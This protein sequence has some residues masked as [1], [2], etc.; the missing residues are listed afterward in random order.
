V[1]ILGILIIAGCATRRKK[2]ETSKLGKFY[3][4]TT[5]EFNGYFNANEIMKESYAILEDN[6]QDNYSKI[7]EPYNFTAATDPKIV[8]PQLDKAIEKVARVAA[9][10][11]PGDWVDD[12]YVLMGQAQFLKKDFETSLETLTFFENEFNPA[13]P[14]GKN[15]KKK[16]ASTKA[17]KEEQENRKKELAND[18]KAKEKEREETKKIADKQREEDKKAREQAAK[19]RKS[20]SR[21][22]SR[23]STRTSSRTRSTTPAKEEPQII[24]VIPPTSVDSSKQ[25]TAVVATKKP[26]PIPEK[27]KKEK[28]DKSAY[29][30]GILWLAMG[31]TKTQQYSSSEYIL[32]RLS[33]MEGLDKKVQRGI[34]PAMADA[35]IQQKAYDEALEYLEQA[36]DN[37]ASKELKGRYAFI[38]GQL[39]QERKD[40]RNAVNYFELARKN[41]GK[42]FKMK[43]MAELFKIKSSALNGGRSESEVA[44][45]LEKML[46]QDKNKPFKDQI[47]FALGEIAVDKENLSKAKEYFTKSIANNT[48][49]N[50]LK[51]EAY[52]YIANMF[53]NVKDYV[54]AKNYYD[55]TALTLVLGDPRLESINQ[56]AKQL[57]T[58]AQNLATLVRL[59]SIMKMADMTK[60]QLDDIALERQ[61]QE[62]TLGK[63]AEAPKNGSAL[64]TGNFRPASQ[65]SSFF[66]YNAISLENGIKEFQQVWGNRDLVDK[67][68]NNRRSGSIT[69][70]DSSTS[71]SESNNNKVS[72]EDYNRLMA[73]VPKDDLDK[74][75]YKAQIGSAL[76]ELGKSL[77]LDL[78]DYTESVKYLERLVSQYPDFQNRLD[79]LYFLYL[80]YSDL[81]QTAEASKI[82]QTI[83][84]EFP[85][86][87]YAKI[88]QDP[89]YSDVLI[90]SSNKLENY[91]KE[92]YSRFVNKSYKETIE[93]S[94]NASDLFGSDNKL[95]PKFSLLN[96][97]STGSLEG[98]EAYIQAL[99]ETIVRY[100]GTDEETRAQEILRFLKGDD[101]AFNAPDI[102]EVDNVFV[103]ED[104]VRHYVAVVIFDYSDDIL[105][106]SKLAI[107]N[108]NTEYYSN[109]NLGIGEA[110]L[111]KEEAT[112]VI[113]I[114][115]FDNLS[116]ATNYC[117]SIKQSPERFITSNITAYEYYPISQANYRKMIQQ[118]TH[119]GYRTFY[120]ANY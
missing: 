28:A 38:A 3:H 10:H 52:Y 4:N 119:N 35:A 120:K 12:C 7:L 23:T 106:K 88:L 24:P 54:Q 15:Y 73:D 18:R 25:V 89:S 51:S 90:A 13:N 8:S 16:K 94:K 46:A 40:Y 48:G 57:T 112:Q 34:A 56:K 20:N 9:L 80:S 19:D 95:M 84:R 71:S 29:W 77:K 86:S 26:E 66:A 76:F 97:M 107:L 91:Y 2:G 41:A 31:Y 109:D 33:E 96:A 111:S 49:D 69:S 105:Q 1:L 22:S 5:S 101:A 17:R 44:G 75:K 21:T 32:K 37:P 92:T 113:L 39:L 6:N 115:S 14:Y 104:N 87:N 83:L 60:D 93:R 82:K 61:K 30:E 43:F 63:P 85:E 114:R 65:S 100:P 42:N 116:R 11:Q 70:N 53:Y 72:E 118:R 78:E 79:A 47:Y 58:V 98:R 62:Q 110:I 68:R 36:I 27:P 67:W 45:E 74:Q 99:Q 55:S 108:Y 117:N 102:K 59:D 81:R 50:A 103:K 64:Y